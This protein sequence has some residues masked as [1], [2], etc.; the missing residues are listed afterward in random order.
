MYIDDT[1]CV[2]D[3]GAVDTFKKEV[4]AHF[5]TKEEGQMNEYVGCKV[6]RESDNEL[7]MYQDDLL[8]KIDKHFGEEIIDIRKCDIP[9]G[10]GDRVIRSK[11][12]TLQTP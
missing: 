9:A 1:L 11:E 7:I 10:T 12:G 6:K 8:V 3:A 4:R 5:D 2:R